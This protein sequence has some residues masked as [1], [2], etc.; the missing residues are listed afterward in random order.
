M[1]QWW[2]YR[3]KFWVFLLGTWL[4]LV[5]GFEP[6]THE[7][8]FWDGIVIGTKLGA[9]YRLPI[10][11]CGKIVMGYFEGF[12]DGDVDGKCLCFCFFIGYVHM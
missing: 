3:L 8:C 11:K 10:W 4:W 2:D 1:F 5:V 7:L 12:I 9:M 6:G